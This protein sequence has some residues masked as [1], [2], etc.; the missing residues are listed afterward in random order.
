MIVGLDMDGVCC[1]FIGGLHDKLKLRGFTL[2]DDTE[3]WDLEQH[4]DADI[5]DIN[6]IVNDKGFWLSLKPIPGA[7]DGVSDLRRWG[8]DVVIVTSPWK[9]SELCHHEKATWAADNLGLDFESVILTHR[10][11]LV[12]CDVLIDDLVDNLVGC[13]AKYPVLFNRPHNKNVLWRGF[14]TEAWPKLMEYLGALRE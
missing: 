10:K 6:S 11:D 7:L 9:G 5:V 3:C 13:T 1:D 4:S 8:W 14:R 12:V 2:T